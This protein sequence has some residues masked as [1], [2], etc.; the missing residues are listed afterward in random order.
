MSGVERMTAKQVAK[1]EV[2]W[3]NPAAMEA[4]GLLFARAG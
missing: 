2:L 3:I 1:T 4:S